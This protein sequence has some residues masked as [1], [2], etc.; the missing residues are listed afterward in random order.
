VVPTADQD[1]RAE[2]FRSAVDGGFTLLELSRHG[3]NLENVFRELTA[4]RQ[5]DA[6]ARPEAG[7]SDGESSGA[8]DDSDRDGGTESESESEAPRASAG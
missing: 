8:A 6:G 7:G 3:E 4:G 5:G 2:L 1:L